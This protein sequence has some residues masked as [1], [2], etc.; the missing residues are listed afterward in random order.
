MTVSNKSIRRN[1][2]VNKPA[3]SAIH[4]RINNTIEFWGTVAA[5]DIAAPY[6]YLIEFERLCSNTVLSASDDTAREP[7]PYPTTA[8]F[9]VHGRAGANRLNETG[10]PPKPIGQNRSGTRGE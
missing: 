1:I 5:R 7:V 10:W 2:G 4:A 9:D 8:L 6:K 3:S